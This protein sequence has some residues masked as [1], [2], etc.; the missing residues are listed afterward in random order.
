MFISLH[1][2]EKP[3]QG[4]LTCFLVLLKR[5]VS[6]ICFLK[7]YAAGREGS[8]PRSF[9]VVCS[10]AVAW[11][12]VSVTVVC[13]TTVSTRLALCPRI[14]V[15]RDDHDEVVMRFPV[16]GAVITNHGIGSN[17]HPRQQEFV[18]G[19]K[20]CLQAQILAKTMFSRPNMF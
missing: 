20:A 9:Q 16:V 18:G 13:P 15:A 4:I 11:R 14:G 7:S 3:D 12:Y 19:A 6:R 17:I 1:T 8:S 5:Y 2:Q 10:T